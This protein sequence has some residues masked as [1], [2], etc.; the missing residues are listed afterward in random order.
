MSGRKGNG[1][2][3]EAEGGDGK[4]EERETERGKVSEKASCCSFWYLKV[5]PV[6]AHGERLDCALPP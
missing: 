5:S 4:R 1:G 3:S 6:A 2:R